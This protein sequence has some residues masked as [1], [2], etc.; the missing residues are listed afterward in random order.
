MAFA[1]KL[2]SQFLC[3]L[4][5]LSYGR[6]LCWAAPLGPDQK[7]AHGTH[8][9]R[10]RKGYFF[11]EFH[12]DE[13]FEYASVSKTYNPFGN[14]MLRGTL[15]AASLG[16][17]LSTPVFGADIS[18]YVVGTSDYVFR[19]V[20]Q[21]DGHAA[22]QAGVDVGFDNGF[23]LG[24]W[25]S[26]VDIVSPNGH[27]REAELR[28]Y[29]GY[30]HAL[31]DNLQLTLTTVS[32]QY[33]LSD[34]NVDY[35]NLETSVALGIADQY[36][37]EY[38]YSPDLYNMDWE[39]HNIEVFGEWPLPNEFQLSAG[40]GQYRVEN[41]ARESSVYWQLGVTRPLGRLD[42]DLRYHDANDTIRFLSR[43]DRIGSR[44][45]L[46]ARLGF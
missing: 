4:T 44:I 10:R 15:L 2:L 6:I 12:T 17:M 27:E 34:G 1:G 42:I 18:G 26:T 22:L 30:S 37:I 20:T 8:R 28:L 11:A 23:F 46:S 31:S 33:P 3:R 24:S 32:Y 5:Q 40:V 14:R 25:A 21:S 35:D 38:A 39:T 29:L 19:G 13:T 43:P 41:I 45:V 9:I 7:A 16:T 36:W